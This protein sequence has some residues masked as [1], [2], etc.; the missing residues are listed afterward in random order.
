MSVRTR[1]SVCVLCYGDFG[2]LSTRCLSSLV[3]WA[4][5]RQTEMDV[6][7]ALNAC[8]A[9]NTAQIVHQCQQLARHAGPV[10]LYV[11]VPAT[12]NVYKYPMMRRMF[13]DQ[14]HPLGPWVMW[15]DDDSYLDF[16]TGWDVEL[17]SVA[18]D[19][20]MVG[21][22]WL[23]PISTRMERWLV[24]QPWFDHSV[25]LPPRSQW[26]ERTPRRIAFHQGAWW[27]ARSEM[28]ARLDWPLRQ[29]RHNGGDS[30]LGEIARHRGYRMGVFDRGVRINAGENGEHSK[31]QRRGYREPNLGSQFDG[32]PYEDADHSFPLT[33]SLV[34]PAGVEQ[35]SYSCENS[36]CAVFYST[37]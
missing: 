4:E 15:L 19:Y 27:L 29:L 36:D 22:R 17:L 16:V 8:S 32:R 18:A 12:A 35:I 28:M 37:S 3:R 26:D 24:Q 25:G 5:H 7:V 2:H 30:L 33:C 21:Q 23:M 9:D 1:I 13:R 11:P 6:R 31:A 10:R 14:R 34:T 20:D